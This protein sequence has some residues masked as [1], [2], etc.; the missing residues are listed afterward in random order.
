MEPS[1]HR[2]RLLHELERRGTVTAVASALDYTVS[3]VSQQLSLLEREAGTPLF[4][5]RGR[6]LVLTEAGLVLA[7]HA[8]TILAAVEDAGHAME[9]AREGG[10]TTL[11]A[12]V[13]AS[14]AT[15]LLPAG[16]RVLGRDHPEISV[17]T[18]E[19][20]PED[21]TGAVRDGSLDLSFVL[22]YSSYPMA[23][24]PDLD[25]LPVAV[26]SLRAVVPQGSIPT[27]EVSLTDLAGAPWVIAH[28][29]SHFGRAVR[30]A[31]REAGFD[32]EVRH[33][34]GEQSTA[35]A[36]VAAG[37]GVTIA[38]DLGLV[39]TPE[40]VDVLPLVESPTRTVSVTFRERD[41]RQRQLRAFVDAFAEAADLMGL[42]AA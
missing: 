17:R 16:L 11:T 40:G 36:L 12:G 23:R 4:E 1:L 20:A 38:S 21:T 15:A 9:S 30:I 34:A 14:V 7:G 19:L 3:A 25:R 13:W 41:T 33:E 29:R 22:D 10:A 27:G 31:C 26:E 39:T 28:P 6:G 24:V 18:R 37:L 32:P 42:P 2:L 8:R 35:L 5:R